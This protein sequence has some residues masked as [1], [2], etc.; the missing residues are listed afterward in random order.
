MQAYYIL[1]E[2]LLAGE[3]QESSKRTVG[4]M[5]ATHVYTITFQFSHITVDVWMLLPY[6]RHCKH[7]GKY[8]RII[9]NT[10]CLHNNN[11][12]T[13]V[14]CVCVCI[15]MTQVSYITGSICGG[16]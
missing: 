15:L 2:L 11:V 10:W 5:I 16:C 9:K 12:Q 1:D 4:R 7:K 6:I 8:G 13:F 14:I 3:L